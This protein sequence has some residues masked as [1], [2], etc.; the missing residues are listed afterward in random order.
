LELN[1]HQ[2]ILSDIALR[3]NQSA[4]D[5]SYAKSLIIPKVQTRLVKTTGIA[6]D[7]EDGLAEPLPQLTT[8]RVYMTA[9]RVHC[10]IAFGEL[11]VNFPEAHISNSIDTVMPALIDIL[12]DVPFIDFDKSLSWE[13]IVFLD[14]ALPDQL[15]FSTVSA[16]LHISS[17]HPEYC[18][19]A[20][21][22]ICFFISQTVK[23]LHES[24][25]FDVLTQLAPAFHGLYRAISSTSYPWTVEQWRTLTLHLKSLCSQ[26]IV[27]QLNHLVVDIVRKENADDDMLYYVQTFVSRYVA[28]GR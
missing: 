22:S 8:S 24:S 5:A 27:D 28:Q 23:K 20:I 21:S 3:T 17:D 4:E 19:P 6:A 10:N 25:S 15:V 16:L 2:R 12:R 14:W 13:G 11:V 9:S 1:I 7:V 18:E 26:A